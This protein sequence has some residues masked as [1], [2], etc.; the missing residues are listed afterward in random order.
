MVEGI[1][2][3]RLRTLRG[4]GRSSKGKDWYGEDLCH[5]RRA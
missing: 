5:Q 2:G 1:Y 3:D 4:A